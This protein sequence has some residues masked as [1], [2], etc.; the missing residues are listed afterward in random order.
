MAIPECRPGRPDELA[1]IFPGAIDEDGMVALGRAAAAE[2]LSGQGPGRAA[3]VV[4]WDTRPASSALQEALSRGLASEGA[5]VLRIGEVPAS[6]VRFAIRR[7]GADTGLFVTGGDRPP[8]WSGLRLYRGAGCARSL[9]LDSAARRARELPGAGL[10]PLRGSVAERDFV[11]EYL[12]G[13]LGAFRPLRER[14]ARGPLRVVVA[15]SHGAGSSATPR[16]LSD[17]GCRVIRLRCTMEVPEGAPAPDPSSAALLRETGLVVRAARADFGIL[18]GGDGDGFRAVDRD[19]VPMCSPLARPLAGED[20]TH[21]ALRL[22][23]TVSR[24]ALSAN[25]LERESR[26]GFRE[27]RLARA[28]SSRIPRRPISRV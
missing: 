5:R 8:E 6:L 1:G 4:G 23:E 15:G 3:V 2:A 16:A 11:P 21:A 7:V 12:A 25:T 17:I 10:L 9:S 27:G 26:V 22:A 20:G 24:N 13:V 19:G 14:L 28:R 18:L